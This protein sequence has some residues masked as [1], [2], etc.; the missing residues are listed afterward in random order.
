M[1]QVSGVNLSIRY[2]RAGCV[3]STNNSSSSDAATSNRDGPGSGPVVTAHPLV[4]PWSTTKL[5]HYDHKSAIEHPTIFEIFQQ[6]GESSVELTH[7]LDMKV[8]VFV[9]SVVVAVGDFA[10][11]HAVF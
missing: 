8:E 7:L 11:R 3:G 4:D 9:V 10:E 6:D 1:E 5:R 2:C